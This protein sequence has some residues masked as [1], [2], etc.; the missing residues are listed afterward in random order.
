[1]QDLINICQNLLFVFIKKEN[2][3]HLICQVEQI[4]LQNVF[5]GIFNFIMFVLGLFLY[6]FTF[7]YRKCS[8]ILNKIYINSLETILSFLV[9]Y[10]FCIKILVRINIYFF[11]IS[12][13]RQILFSLITDCIY[14]KVSCVYE[15][16]REKY[17]VIYVKIK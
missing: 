2:Y 16:Q 6:P 7:I 12:L 14:N 13:R 3:L 4:G 5:N 11:L 1:M 10:L 15:S 9:A 17:L 8:Q